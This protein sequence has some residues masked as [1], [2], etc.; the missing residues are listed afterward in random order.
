MQCSPQR[1]LWGLAM[2]APGAP[3]RSFIMTPIGK[4]T[5]ASSVSSVRSA[6]PGKAPGPSPFA[7]CTAQRCPLP[8]AG[9]PACTGLK[10]GVPGQLLLCAAPGVA[11]HAGDVRQNPR[12]LGNM[13]LLCHTLQL[14]EQPRP[15]GSLENRLG[16]G[17][18]TGAERIFLLSAT[19]R[20]Y[21]TEPVEL[22]KPRPE[23]QRRLSVG[24][25]RSRGKAALAV[26]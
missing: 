9:R 20:D 5:V 26:I 8:P 3:H 22:A 12:A 4:G 10:P 23:N 16:R 7:P 13:H 18:R 21:G 25:S 15:G 17:R 19:V 2:L 11:R 1:G 6:A 14:P 24:E